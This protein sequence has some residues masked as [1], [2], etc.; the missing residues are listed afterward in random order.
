MDDIVALVAIVA[1]VVFGIVCVLKGLR[2]SLKTS[3]DGVDI[4]AD[5]SV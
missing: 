2:P 4:R 3:P 5:E 1:I